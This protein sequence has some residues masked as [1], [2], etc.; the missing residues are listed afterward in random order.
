MIAA[1]IEVD[2]RT[3]TAAVVRST[4]LGD[5]PLP[6]P[7][8]PGASGFENADPP[9]SRRRAGPMFERAAVQMAKGMRYRPVSKNGEPV[10][11]LV[12]FPVN[13]T[14]RRGGDRSRV[15]D[16]PTAV[17]IPVR[18]LCGRE[19]RGGETVRDTVIVLRALV[20]D[21]I[22]LAEKAESLRRIFST[23][24][25]FEGWF[26]DLCRL[27]AR[28]YLTRSEYHY[29][30][31]S[32]AAAA[33]RRNADSTARFPETVVL[34]APPDSSVFGHFP[35]HTE[36]RWNTVPGAA[37]YVVEVEVWYDAQ[38]SYLPHPGLARQV[39]TEPAFTFRFVG[40][41]HGRWRVRA[42]DVS[43]VPGA[44]SVWRYFV[45]LN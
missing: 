22:P 30:L 24:S 36:L 38:A 23:D 1:V 7:P 3:R 34:V 12:C 31:D 13:F 8:P 18:S 15:A 9:L 21:S 25:T 2:G 39:V 41:Q 37:R 11:V 35:R 10:R 5:T 44:P 29:L 17:A 6:Q 4:V 32:V 28:S 20:T 16:R 33:A 43:G 45:Y 14:L 19:H 26:A 42:L 40:A 27:A